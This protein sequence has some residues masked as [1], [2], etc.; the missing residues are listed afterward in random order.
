MFLGALGGVPH[1]GILRHFDLR[2]IFHLRFPS[3]RC[4]AA[5]FRVRCRHRFYRFVDRLDRPRFGRLGRGPFRIAVESRGDRPAAIFLR[6]GQ[7]GAAMTVIGL[8]HADR[9]VV[10]APAMVAQIAVMADEI[11]LAAPP[12]HRA[13]EA[14]WQRE[15]ELAAILL[16]DEERQVGE[17]FAER[18]PVRIL[19]RY[20]GDHPLLAAQYRREFP[21]FH[22]TVPRPR[23]PVPLAGVNRA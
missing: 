21:E 15:I 11:L 23:T 1:F 18:V 6:L 9:P 8:Q 10:V 3:T 16:L 13:H 2:R 19:P 12:Q 7:R 22:S 5:M 14:V 4:S 17:P 20:G